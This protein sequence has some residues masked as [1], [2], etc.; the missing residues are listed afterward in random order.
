MTAFV[1]VL[2]GVAA[3]DGGQRTGG[4][5]ERVV[6]TFPRRWEGTWGYTVPAQLRDGELSV[7]A[8]GWSCLIEMDGRGAVLVR[9]KAGDLPWPGRYK[10]EGGRL[11][12]WWSLTK[13]DPPARPRDGNDVNLFVLR[14]VARKP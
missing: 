3:G 11:L 2:A 14:P 13:D 5:S 12:I 7:P 6:S 9:K 1:L 4:G 8:A 10:L